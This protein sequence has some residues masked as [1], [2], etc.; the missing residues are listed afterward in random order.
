VSC[1]AEKRAPPA[2]ADSSQYDPQISPT[3]NNKSIIVSRF[4]P[5]P[6]HEANSYAPIEAYLRVE[7]ERR[8]SF[9]P[10]KASQTRVAIIQDAAAQARWRK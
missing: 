2:E 5:Q 7:A 10:R 8:S 3:D 4:F 1:R 9:G 6:F